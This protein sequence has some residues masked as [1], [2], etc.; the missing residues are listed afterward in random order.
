M[1]FL[2][3]KWVPALPEVP[4]S[5][6]ICEYYSNEAYGRKAIAHSRAP[7]TCGITGLSYS[8]S[9]VRD[10]TEAV[11]RALAR[12]LEIAPNQA[13][14]WDKVVCVFSA[15]AVSPELVGSFDCLTTQR[16]FL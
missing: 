13:T 2:P 14:E 12:R 1:V 8:A 9:E 6:P 16:W 5:I 15:N 10:R 4:D 7:Y 11:S 3:P